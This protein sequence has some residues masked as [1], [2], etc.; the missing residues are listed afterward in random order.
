MLSRSNNAQEVLSYLRMQGPTLSS[1]LVAHF[2]ISRPTLSCRVQEL[3]QSVVKLGKGRST[4]LAARHEKAGDAVRLYQVRVNG[5]VD[6]FGRL[7]ANND[8]HWGNLSFFLPKASP[9]P[10]APIYD[11]L[12]LSLP[13]MTLDFTNSHIC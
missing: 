12:V 9:F 13:E 2:G 1:E 10:L 5:Q 6:A 11:M 3:G 8:M 7:I 4:R